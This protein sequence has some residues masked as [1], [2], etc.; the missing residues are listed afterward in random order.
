M[1]NAGFIF[2]DY[3]IKKEPLELD[4]VLEEAEA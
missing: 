2:T 3:L 4:Y 1:R